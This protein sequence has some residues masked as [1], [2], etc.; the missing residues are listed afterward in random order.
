MGAGLGTGLAGYWLFKNDNVTDWD[1]PQLR[2]RFDGAA[3]VM[4]N[5]GIGVNFLGHPAWG[6]LGYSIARGNHQS[7]PAA[8]AYTFLTSF[9]WEFVVEFKEKVSVNDVVVTPGAAVPIGEFFYKLG[10]YLDT[11]HGSALPVQALRWLLGTGV[12]MDRSFDGRDPPHV[13]RFDNL[14]FSR[15]IWHQF[16]AD[17]GVLAVSADSPTAYARYFVEGSARLVTLRGYGRAGSFGRGFFGGEISDLAFGSELSRHGGGLW[18]EADTLLAGYHLQAIER[19]AHVDYGSSLTLGASM[20]YEYLRS[21]AN[22]YGS[23]RE[24]T[25]RELLADRNQFAALD[26]PGLG[27]DVRGVG[28]F[29]EASLSL[30]LEPSFGAMGVPVYY[31]W[32]PLHPGEQTKH[33][34]SRHGYFYGWGGSLRVRGRLALGPLRVGADLRYSS[35]ESQDGM[36]RFQE[37]VTSDDHVT[38]NVL[39]ASAWLGVAPEGS[40]LS[41]S[42]QV[43][44]R[45]FRSHMADLDLTRRTLERGVRASFEF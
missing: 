44:V 13:T 17:Y 12:A 29:G 33:V 19:R 3:W 5:N 42:A 32:Q 8:F 10:L 20:G 40:P 1:N 25:D 7:V 9:I 26:L 34:L 37:Q 2:Q 28:R 43:G 11:G 41:I 18:A 21:S 35:M 31:A 4:D 39:R 24:A 27:A 6:A 23:D 30:R 45:Q 22:H 38:G 36:D 15:Q 16:N 14:G